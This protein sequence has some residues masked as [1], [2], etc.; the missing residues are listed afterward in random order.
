MIF[1]L[2]QWVKEDKALLILLM[3]QHTDQLWCS[4]LWE[5]MPIKY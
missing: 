2:S 5:I 4:H 1:L 3:K